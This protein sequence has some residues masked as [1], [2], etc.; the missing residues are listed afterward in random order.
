M[1]GFHGLASLA[2]AKFSNIRRCFCYLI[3]PAALVRLLPRCV[4]VA[5]ARNKKLQAKA[6]LAG[7]GV[8]SISCQNMDRFIPSRVAGQLVCDQLLFTGPVHVSRGPPTLELNA[9]FWYHMGRL[10][11]LC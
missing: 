8:P 7:A 9:G 3:S 4:L 10:L 11:C 5:R 1:R 2:G 6:G